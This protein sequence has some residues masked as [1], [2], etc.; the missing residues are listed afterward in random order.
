MGHRARRTP[1]KWLLGSIA[2]GTLIAS[3]IYIGAIRAWGASA[4][5]IIAAA[6]FGIVGV[7]LIAMAAMSSRASE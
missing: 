2:A 1:P 3:G 4:E 6:A 7:V 5:R